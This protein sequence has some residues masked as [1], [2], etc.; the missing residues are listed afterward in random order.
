MDL[1]HELK[2]RADVVNRI[3]KEHTPKSNNKYSKGLFEAM[4]Y[5]LWS[6]GKRIRPILM[7]EMFDVLGG[8]YEE[9]PI[10]YFIPAIEMIH[11]YSLIHDD[12]PCIDN[13][14]YRRGKDTCHK[15]F[16]EYTALL[17]GNALLNYAYE[18]VIKGTIVTRNSKGMEAANVLAMSAGCE[19]MV[20]GE[21]AELTIHKDNITEDSLDYVNRN[22]TG[23]LITASLLIGAIL[24]GTDMD[25]LRTVYEFGYHIGI[26]FQLRDDIMDYDKDLN[27]LEVSHATMFGI[28]KSSDKI[29]AHKMEALKILEEIDGDNKEF[30]IEL[31]NYFCEIDK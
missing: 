3:I 29:N 2:I 31:I 14:D 26:I 27:N 25:T 11:T 7:K 16:N 10:N 1:K 9:N 24:A 4:E 5:S 28:E 12:L 22:K 13:D 19:G 30:F 23:E 6:G 8:D 21:Y 18:L 15:K 17:A 20:A